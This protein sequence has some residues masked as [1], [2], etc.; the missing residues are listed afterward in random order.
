MDRRT[1]YRA[2]RR[3]PYHQ[4]RPPEI[5][6]QEAGARKLVLQVADSESLIVVSEALAEKF[7]G[8]S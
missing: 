5:L 8:P 7:F 1:A 4:N 6:A 2:V 3:L